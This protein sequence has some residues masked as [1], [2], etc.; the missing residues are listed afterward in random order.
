MQVKTIII[1]PPATAD[2]SK[3][4]APISIFHFFFTGLCVYVAVLYA[5]CTLYAPPIAIGHAE[6]I[7]HIS[8]GPV[9]ILVHMQTLT[10]HSASASA[11][12]VPILKT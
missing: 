12:S 5:V 9:H 4:T 10:N 6:C 7:R 2:L 1:R 11:L 8:S 3:F